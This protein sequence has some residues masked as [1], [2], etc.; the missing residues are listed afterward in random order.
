M[1]NINDFKKLDLRVAKIIAVEEHPD[2]DKLYV[3]KIDVSG[4]EKQLVA[5][6]RQY[7]TPD[8]LVG[9]SI[10]VV[11]NLEPANIRGV[12]SNGMLLAAS[13]DEGLTIVT[14]DRDIATGSKV[15]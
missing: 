5:G 6:I 12:E 2:A 9:K 8:E 4:Q 14:T 11:N 10:V 3:V 13:N 1:L 15:R 7:Y